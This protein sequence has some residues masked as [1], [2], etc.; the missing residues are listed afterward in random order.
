MLI[1]AFFLS[2]GVDGRMWVL[3]ALGPA[4]LGIASRLPGDGSDA[5]PR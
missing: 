1:A 2:G 3:F 4:L 5:G